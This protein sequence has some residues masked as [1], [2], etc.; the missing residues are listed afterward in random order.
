MESRG[1]LSKRNSDK[2]KKIQRNK[3]DWDATSKESS[4]ELIQETVLSG[5][6]KYRT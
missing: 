4:T 5:N 6:Y 3:D 2:P 1:I